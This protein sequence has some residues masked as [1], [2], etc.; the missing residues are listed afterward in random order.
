MRGTHGCVCLFVS[1]ELRSGVSAKDVVLHVI[2][3]IGKTDHRSIPSAHSCARVAHQMRMH[4]MH[5]YAWMD[6]VQGRR[7]A[8]GT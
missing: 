1:G 2:G 6:A 5:G 7:V 8:R 3:L 4:G